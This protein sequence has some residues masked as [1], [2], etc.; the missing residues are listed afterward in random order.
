[1]PAAGVMI[2]MARRQFGQTF[3]SNTD[4]LGCRSI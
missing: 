2:C 4:Q 1:M 3:E